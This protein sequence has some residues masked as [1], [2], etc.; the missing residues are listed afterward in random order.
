MYIVNLPAGAA[1]RGRP[2]AGRR[3]AR[4]L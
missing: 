4:R 1:R 2:D 3:Y